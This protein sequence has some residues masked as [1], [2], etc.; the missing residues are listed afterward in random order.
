M[1]SPPTLP[2]DR[3]ATRTAIAPPLSAVR[4]PPGTTLLSDDSGLAH[5]SGYDLTLPDLTS[6]PLT[7]APVNCCGAASRITDRKAPGSI[8]LCRASYRSRDQAGD[9]CGR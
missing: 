4:R 1:A 6:A 2:A 5:S 3:P 7:V 9:A 8:R